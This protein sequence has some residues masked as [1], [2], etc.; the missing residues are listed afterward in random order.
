MKYRTCCIC[1]KEK[2]LS[3][4]YKDRTKKSGLSDTCKECSKKYTKEYSKNHQDKII[5]YQRNYREK[6]KELINKQ[7][8]QYY[9]ENKKELR[10]YRAKYRI[11]HKEEIKEQ[12]IQY[13]LKY[14]ERI[15]NH[16]LR[17]NHG[18]MLE[19]YNRMLELQNNV[20]AICGEPETSKEVNRKVKSL[21]VDHN[22]KTGKIRGLLCGKCNKAIGLLQ[23]NTELLQ[24]AINYL[25]RNK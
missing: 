25:N 13:R 14:P 4:F 23:D 6:N 10:A 21:A 16:D 22:H 11:E 7:Q 17:S 9:E 18:I 8:K 24:S 19:E 15:K 2:S 1:D 12:Q 5:N 3:D 20:C